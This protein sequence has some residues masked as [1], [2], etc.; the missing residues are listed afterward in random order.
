MVRSVP[1]AADLLRS[2]QGYDCRGLFRLRPTPKVWLIAPARLSSAWRVVWLSRPRRTFVVDAPC[3]CF[4][5]SAAP[6]SRT[7]QGP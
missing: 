2:P 5:S 7:R 4:A 1:R 6:A 3:C